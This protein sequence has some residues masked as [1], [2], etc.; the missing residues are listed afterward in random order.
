MPFRCWLLTTPLHHTVFLFLKH[1]Q[2]NNTTQTIP[3][4]RIYLTVLAKIS[5]HQLRNNLKNA[6][7]FMPQIILCHQIGLGAI[8]CF[9][10]TMRVG[11]HSTVSL[12][13]HVEQA[14]LPAVVGQLLLAVLWLAG[15]CC[16]LLLFRSIV[17]VWYMLVSLR[18][19]MHSGQF[20]V[21]MLD[22]HP[23]HVLWGRDENSWDTEEEKIP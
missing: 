21:I 14:G 12:T 9:S 8:F 6:I 3:R 20:G 16:Q 15:D 1:T 23:C 4:K 18:G 7:W 17:K 5:S 19:R 22:H 13:W 10:D 11:T 2:Y